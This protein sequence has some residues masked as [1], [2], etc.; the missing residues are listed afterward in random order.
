MG[1]DLP[2]EV[3]RGGTVAI[4]LKAYERRNNP[5]D[6]EIDSKPRHGALTGFHQADPNRQG[7]ASVIYTHGDDETSHADEFTFRVRAVT[8]GGASRAIKVKVRIL[9]SPPKL[10]APQHLVFSAIAGENEV[11]KVGLTNAGGAI[12]E[13][14]L[15]PEA[16]FYTEGG[17]YFRLGR[18]QSTN[19]A[20]RF[21]PQSTAGVARQ[22]LTPAPADPEGQ[23]VIT[24]EAHEP[25]EAEAGAFE[26]HPDGAREGQIAVTNFSS[27]PLDL[28]LSPQPAGAA[29]IPEKIRVAGKGRREIPVRLGA[30][31]KGGEQE[32]L[33]Q[34]SNRFYAQ[35]LSLT[36]PA[37]PP[38]LAVTTPELDF[39][40]Q[41]EVELRVRN[42][43]GVAGRFLLELPKNIRSAERAENFPVPPGAERT[44]R[45][46]FEPGG[47]GGTAPEAVIVDLGSGEKVSV[48]TLR[49][50]PPPE[51]PKQVM[52]EL[53]ALPPELPVMPWRLN[54]DVKLIREADGSTSL[55]W[56]A[57]KPDWTNAVLEI[58][59]LAGTRT[60]EPAEVEESWWDA[61]KAWWFG[62]TAEAQRALEEKQKYF[63]NRTRLPGEKEEP[64]AS[65]QESAWLRVTAHPRD[66]KDNSLV[67]RVSAEKLPTGEQANV[68]GNFRADTTNQILTEAREASEAAP[69][70]GIAAEQTPSKTPV[71]RI[72]GTSDKPEKTQ[73]TVNLI[74]DA[75]PSIT[76]Y[77]LERCEMVT[78]TG[79][80]P[81]MS[82]P[83]FRPIPHKGS[84]TILP[85]SEIEFEGKKLSLVT[86]SMDG[87]E[88]GTGTFWRL[89]PLA[90]ETAMPPTGE[91]FVT[92]L[93]PWSFPWRGFFLLVCA[94]LG[95]LML[96]LRWKSRRLPA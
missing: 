77:R 70:P 40:T 92:T 54:E 62:R 88:P 63:E 80:T 57:A 13:G 15:K 53:P 12:L 37:V 39:R 75:P 82:Q 24:G 85:P 95:I 14:S 33:I 46:Q 16:P 52:H 25:F 83:S 64:A 87:L 9:D 89:I 31:K 43:G 20:I 61:L 65:T 49:P 3:M 90:G 50:A 58:T 6:Y 76:G 34:L 1:D 7:F 44:I 59:D 29:E 94:A 32:L 56:L 21:S 10:A 11:Q 45:L 55:M 47:H 30:D 22:K 66:L 2:V 4:T 17:G 19:I 23:I 71:C 67:W 51:P 91:F 35:T 84:T 69:S 18:R 86:A 60:Y 93:P 38:E 73:A 78:G 27:S 79:N 96:W 81:T 28:T 8:G 26:L 48:P 42:S 72:V 68:S 36:I 74:L 41:N 5:L